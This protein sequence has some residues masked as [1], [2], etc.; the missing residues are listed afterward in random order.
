MRPFGFSPILPCH[1]FIHPSIHPSVHPYVQL[2]SLIVNSVN[3]S[4]S[5]TQL[6]IQLTL[7][8]YTRVCFNANLFFLLFQFSLARPLNPIFPYYPC[9]DLSISDLSKSIQSVTGSHLSLSLSLSQYLTTVIPY[10][11]NNGPPSVED[12][13]YLTKSE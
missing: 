8:L 7:R 4:C 2:F 6:H 10:E 13:Q 11:Q 12:L 1:P 9:M 3:I 5:L